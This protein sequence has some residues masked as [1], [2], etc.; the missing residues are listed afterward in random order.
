M[1]LSNMAERFLLA[2]FLRVSTA[3][4]LGVCH[5]IALEAVVAEVFPLERLMAEPLLSTKYL[6]LYL[7]GHLVETSIY[8]VRAR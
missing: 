2:I 7:A 1:V 5:G 3:V 4:Q 6:G 8:L